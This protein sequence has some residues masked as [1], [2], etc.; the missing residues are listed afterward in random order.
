MSYDKES[1]I[2]LDVEVYK[3]EGGALCS[4]LYRK[5]TTGNK[6]L[7]AASFHP[8]SL[9]DLIPYSRYLRIRCNCSDDNIYKIEAAKLRDRL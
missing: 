4:K 5:P 2:F 7:H 6:I 8:K 3:G 9:I 1:I